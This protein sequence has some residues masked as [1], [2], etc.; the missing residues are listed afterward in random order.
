MRFLFARQK[1]DG[2]LA[3]WRR[4]GVRPR[5]WWRDDDVRGPTPALDR[6]LGLTHG[7]P[8]ALAAIPD[9][10][11]EGLARRISGLRHV[12]VGQ[13]GL[14]HVNRRDAGPPSE[15]GSAP[16]LG[17]VA[18][19]VG[20]GLQR[21]R[22]AGLEPR[23]YTPPW[24]TVDP[25]LAPALAGLGFPLLSAGDV[26]VVHASL[27]YA[28]AEIDVLAWKRGPAFKGVAR[29]L[30]ELR[31]ALE[32]RRER[33]DFHRPIGLL[34]HHLVHDEAA[35]R[36]LSWAPSWLGERFDWTSLD[37]LASPSAPSPSKRE[38]IPVA[39][40]APGPARPM[41]ISPSV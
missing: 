31:R 33:Q 2:E 21:M 34:T 13:H 23:F 7:R 11:L 6:L 18:A 22:A 4:R 32:D 26:Q 38:R 15:Y 35:W 3:R 40:P 25:G 29:V 41:A 5:L 17:Q 39:K 19:R 1:L 9:G 10:D 27:P 14:D 37:D 8:I 20:E 16:S 36:F 28:S 30:T 24:N 12:S